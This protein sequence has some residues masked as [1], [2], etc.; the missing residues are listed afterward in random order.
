MSILLQIFLLVQEE[1][2][3]VDAVADLEDVDCE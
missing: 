1:G 3:L 2:V